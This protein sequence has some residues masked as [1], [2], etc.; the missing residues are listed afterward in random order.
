MNTAGNPIGSIVFFY[1]F[2][3]VMLMYLLYAW[4]EQHQIMLQS[5]P[6]PI[7]A[8]LLGVPDSMHMNDEVYMTLQV[9]NSSKIFL[10]KVQVVC[11]TI[12][13][14][15]LAPQSQVDIPIRLDTTHA[16]KHQVTASVYCRQWELHIS[17]WYH[18]LQR[19]VSQREK[20]LSVLGLK[21]G[22][23]R[24]EIKRARK[25][26]AKKYHPDMGAGYEEKMKEINEAYDKL[27]AS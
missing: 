19:I 24:A 27:M 21:A 22:A 1:I 20:Y 13:V 7:S 26:L 5:M 3:G 11:G 25:R 17:V 15:S 10:K 14:F 12:W 2:F 23:T 8:Q 6:N 9:E 4:W 16:G 18:V